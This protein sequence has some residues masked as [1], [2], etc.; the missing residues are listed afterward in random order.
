MSRATFDMV[1]P[2][3]AST[4]NPAAGAAPATVTVPAGKRWL[5]ISV[6]NSI[7]CSGDAANRTARL[8]ISHDG[9]TT[10]MVFIHGTVSTATQTSNY[11][12]AQGPFDS[13]GLTG[14]NYGFQKGIGEAIELAAGATIALSYLNMQAADD[15]GVM[16]YVYKELPA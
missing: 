1:P 7:V 6:I 12:F 4:A 3:L 16:T 13:Q 11:L 15:C 5:L 2:K 14:A 8:V 9:T 10:S